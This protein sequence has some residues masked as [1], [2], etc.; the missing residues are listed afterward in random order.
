MTAPHDLEY[1]GPMRTQR[2]CVALLV[3]QHL[4][5][6]AATSTSAPPRVPSRLAEAEHALAHELDD[7]H[8]AASDA[9]EVR[10]F[11]HFAPEGVFLGTDARERWTVPE[12]REYAHPR[13]A[14]GK[15]WSFR[16]TRRTFGMSDA[17]TTAWF[18]EDLET[19]KLGPAR[20]SGVLVLRKGRWLIAQYNLALVV[21]N[22]RFKDVKAVLDGTK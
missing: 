18:E 12:F 16:S 15:A 5:C 8:L 21:P 6:A 14:K 9:D 20:G 10:Y 1:A 19:E 7:F 2:F 17:G 22:E 4:G 11:S 3:L 13:F